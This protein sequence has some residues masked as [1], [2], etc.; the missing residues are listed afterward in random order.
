MFL[1]ELK[2]SFSDFLRP[3]FYQVTFTG[4][5]FGEREFGFLTRGATFPF[6]TYNTESVFYNNLPRHFA[7]SIDYDPIPFE[8]LVDDGLKIMRFFDSWRKLV[9]NDGSRTFNYK[10]EY[11]G[12]IEVELWNRKQFMR[13]K[14]T[15]L[16]AFPV[17]IDNFALAAD[18]N[19][20]LLSMT[21]SFRYDDI[22]YEFDDGF[23]VAGIRDTVF[24]L[25]QGTVGTGID[26]L[27][28][29]IEQIANRIPDSTVKGIFG[30]VGQ[31]STGFPASEEAL[32]KTSKEALGKLSGSGGK[33]FQAAAAN[34]KNIAAG[35]IGGNT[36]LGGAV[37]SVRKF[38][39]RAALNSATSRVT[40]RAK[41]AGIA[42]AKS[43]VSKSFKIPKLFG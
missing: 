35:A 34:A 2:A 3:N 36:R 12:Q 23:S 4:N 8:F 22:Q 18:A 1:E 15:M 42:K 28:D 38:A 7:N 19:D 24:D 26:A 13:A 39:S 6:L 40:G 41:R 21:V 31:P 5:I 17:N 10:A 20:Q 9:M 43:F 37:S 16:D 27:K 11:A 25:A 33:S 30:G 29:G 14:C 32:S